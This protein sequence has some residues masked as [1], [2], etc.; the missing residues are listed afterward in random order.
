MNYTVLDYDGFICKSFFAA[1]RDE[2]DAQLILNDLTDVALDKASEYFDNEE[3]NAYFIVSGHSWKKDLY[4]D[5]K[6][7]REKDPYVGAYRDY[8][9]DTVSNIVKPATLEADELCVMVHD[10]AVEHGDKC[11]IFSD[12]KDLRYS[13]LVN[14]KVNLTERVDLSYDERYLYLQMLAGDKEDYITGI[15]KVGMKIAEKLLMENGY[16][17]EGVIKTYRDKN[18]SLEDCIKN[19][20]LIIPM[21]REFNTKRKCYDEACRKLIKDYELDEYL[22]KHI[23]TGQLEFIEKKARE[24]YS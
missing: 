3:F 22:L 13:S 10:Y 11:I 21:K 5:Y 15:P 6:K 12:D 19:I 17:I 20:N 7:S 14:C 4:N 9:I 1:H 8:I 23:Q 24:I 2:N 16:N 18:I